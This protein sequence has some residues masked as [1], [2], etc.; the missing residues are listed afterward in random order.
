MKVSLGKI[1]LIF[2]FV[3]ILVAVTIQYRMSE[4]FVS[5]IGKNQAF[6]ELRFLT[7]YFYLVIGLIGVLCATIGAKLKEDP[8]YTVMGFTT[9]IIGMVILCSKMW[10]WM[11]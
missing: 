7:R 5:S 10:L 6:F 1:S 2:G 9:S 11:L 4:V 3:S 8:K